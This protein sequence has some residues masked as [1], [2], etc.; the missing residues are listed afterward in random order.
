MNAERWGAKQKRQ[1]EEQ[2]GVAHKGFS[3]EEIHDV[4][5][6]VRRQL[7]RHCV[8]LGDPK[9]L[10][11]GGNPQTL[12]AGTGTFAKNWRGDYG[13]ITAAHVL[14]RHDNTA[15]GGEIAIVCPS[16]EGGAEDVLARYD[17]W[18]WRTR[19]F[20]NTGRDGPDIAWIPLTAGDVKLLRTEGGKT[21]HPI[22]WDREE[23]RREE[24]R[25]RDGYPVSVA[26]GARQ[27]ATDIRDEQAE[28]AGAMKMSL[29]CVHSEIWDDGDTGDEDYVV[30][31]A[32]WT[33]QS[34]PA[35][36]DGKSTEQELAAL[37]ALDREPVTRR[38]WAGMSGGG[39]WN[40]KMYTNQHGELT[41]EY[42]AV[43]A[44]VC[45][46]ADADRGVL[47]GHGTRSIDGIAH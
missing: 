16:E 30:L 47:R 44:G 26:L 3:E 33:G 18:R 40:V 29:T 20:E 9:G 39:F 24:T 15:E 8:L 11:N 32:E 23:E 5:N 12:A 34:L 28:K 37:Q 13:I 19:G 6:E 10:R 1:T 4:V 2:G 41:G 14:R 21:P 17:R 27:A 7:T 46:Y 42:M 31:E 22:G 36:W 45:F 43:L 25:Q 38:A 35:R